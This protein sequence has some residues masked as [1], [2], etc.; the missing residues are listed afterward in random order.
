M[1]AYPPASVVAREHNKKMVVPIDSKASAAT[2]D[3]FNPV[4]I[5]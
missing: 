4:E 2:A 3:D 5:F 1:Q